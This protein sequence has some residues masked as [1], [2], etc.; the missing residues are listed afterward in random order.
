MAQ[1]TN[2]RMQ[3]QSERR[4]KRVQEAHCQSARI[5]GYPDSDHP[6]C[7]SAEQD[8][9]PTVKHERYDDIEGKA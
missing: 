4:E 2:R 3:T 9:I 8:E 6:L 1:Q 7:D 5:D